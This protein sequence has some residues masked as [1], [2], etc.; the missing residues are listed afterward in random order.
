MFY[1]TIFPIS[2]SIVFKEKMIS[3]IGVLGLLMF[4]EF[5]N[6]ILH[7]LLGDLTHHSPILMLTFMVIIAA[8][9]IPLHHKIEHWILKVVTEKNKKIRLASA[10]KTIK[11]LENED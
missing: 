4:F 5:I 3:F 2:R 11:E 6:L 7:P 10:K 1:W 8:A 9:I